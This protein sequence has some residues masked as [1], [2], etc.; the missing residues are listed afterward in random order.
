MT[1][2][3]EQLFNGMCTCSVHCANHCEPCHCTGW[4]NCWCHRR[5]YQLMALKK[6]SYTEALIAL[7]LRIEP[8]RSK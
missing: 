8:K 5:V 3:G 7:G 6:I 2:S 1:P 4:C